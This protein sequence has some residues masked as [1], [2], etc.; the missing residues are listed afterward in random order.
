MYRVFVEIVGVGG[1][2]RY[3]IHP[4]TQFVETV[5]CVYYWTQVIKHLEGCL[6]IP[7]CII[8]AVILNSGQH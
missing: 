2:A 8:H 4:H 6:F 1:L 3:M 7:L 5:L